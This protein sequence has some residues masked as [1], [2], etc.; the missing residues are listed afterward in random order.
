MINQKCFVKH[1]QYLLNTAVSASTDELQNR[2][3]CPEEMIISKAG[4]AGETQR[5]EELKFGLLGSAN[6]PLV[7]AEP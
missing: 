4:C 6:F 5:R 1:T 7:A 3:I 2:S